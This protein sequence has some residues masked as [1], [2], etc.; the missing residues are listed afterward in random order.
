MA[1]GR[2]KELLKETKDKLTSDKTD[3][4]GPPKPPMPIFLQ[5]DFYIEKLLPVA[6]FIKPFFPNMERD[7]IQAEMEDHDAVR[8]IAESLYNGL[9]FGIVFSFMLIAAGIM[10]EDAQLQSWGTFSFPV[11]F[12]FFT[13]LFAKRPRIKAKKRTRRLEKELPYALRHVLIEVE[14]GVSLYRAMVSVSDGYGEA[15]NEFERIINQINGGKSE[16]EALENAIMRNPSEQYRK[17]LWQIINSLKSGSDV[18]D[19][20]ET[21]VE[22]IMKE[23]IMSVQKY[24]K[25]LNPYTMIYLMI[26]IIMPSLGITFIMIMSTITGMTIGNNLFYMILVGLVIFQIVFINMITSKR[27]MVKT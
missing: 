17:A 18:S 20:L 11:V 4:D 9:K 15:S 3:E 22:S 1:L 12:L 26:A 10:L 23:Q 14:A 27:P 13:F 7:L 6:D 16:I 2:F 25:E 24:G 19:T 21:L 5:G 8:H